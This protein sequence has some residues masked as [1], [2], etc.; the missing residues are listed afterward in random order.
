MLLIEK[1]LGQLVLADNSGGQLGLVEDDCIDHIQK[2]CGKHYKC[3]CRWWKMGLIWLMERKYW[4]DIYYEK[5]YETQT[6]YLMHYF[7]CWIHHFYRWQ[8]ANCANFY[9]LLRIR[10]IRTTGWTWMFRSSRRSRMAFWGPSRPK[11]QSCEAKF[12]AFWLPSP[13]SSCLETSG[14]SWYQRCAPNQM[15]QRPILISGTPACKPSATSART[16]SQ[17]T[18]ETKWKTR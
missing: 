11:R 14:T 7:S 10:S 8:L 12:Q 13:A 9:I 3:K 18:C 5:N 16:W 17:S 6:Q 2:F 15:S 1:I 4:R